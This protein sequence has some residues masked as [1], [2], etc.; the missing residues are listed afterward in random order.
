[1]SAFTM[2]PVSNPRKVLRLVRCRIGKPYLFV[3]HICRVPRPVALIRSGRAFAIST[4]S[5][6]LLPTHAASIQCAL[7]KPLCVR[8]NFVNPPERSE[9]RRVGRECRS[10]G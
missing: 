4:F 1:M 9:E 10:R 8:L 6:V 7:G 2:S 3:E 5:G